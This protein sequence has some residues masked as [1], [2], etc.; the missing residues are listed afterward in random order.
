MTEADKIVR[1]ASL[2]GQCTPQPAPEPP[3]TPKPRLR[4][5]DA[6][7]EAAC[8]ALDRDFGTKVISDAVLASV[9]P[10]DEAFD[11]VGREAV[12]ALVGIQPKNPVEAMLA[13]QMIGVHN[14]A[15]D[16]LRLAR[17]TIG[18]HR[19]MHLDHANR[20]CRTFAALAEAFD[21]HR[22]R[23]KQTVVVQHVYPG[24]QAVGMVNNG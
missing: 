8:G 14:A 12:A 4:V 10:E 9:R 7:F 1:L 5:R 19:A 18:P 23:G 15:A 3:P 22:N 11:Q 6:D 21:R 20:L 13:A 2:L 16:S 24:G 17:M